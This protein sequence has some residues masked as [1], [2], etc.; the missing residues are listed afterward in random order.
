[1]IWFLVESV[2]PTKSGYQW[3]AYIPQCSD[4]YLVGDDTSVGR[5]SGLLCRLLHQGPLY[6]LS[7][8][9]GGVALPR[10]EQ[11]SLL[12]LRL[13]QGLTPLPANT[14]LAMAGGSVSRSLESYWDH[15]RVVLPSLNT[16]QLL[17]KPCGFENLKAQYVMDA[18][19]MTMVSGT[20]WSCTFQVIV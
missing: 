3:P 18:S 7:H 14:S 16:L 8:S 10:Q 19:A 1:M 13:L 20:W 11:V 9:L 12:F 2:L 15:Q 6:G 4:T 5:Q 17:V